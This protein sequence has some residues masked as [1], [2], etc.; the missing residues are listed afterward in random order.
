LLAG[1]PFTQE[2]DMEKMSNGRYPSRSRRLSL[3]KNLRRDM[4]ALVDQYKALG[5]KNDNDALIRINECLY[6]IRG[7]NMEELKHAL[8]DMGCPEHAS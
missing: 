4:K 3:Y 2:A 7:L 1:N 5:L 8:E 6:L